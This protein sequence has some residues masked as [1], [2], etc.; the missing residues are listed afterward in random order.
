MVQYLK[1]VLFTEYLQIKDTIETILFT[2]PM[3]TFVVIHVNVCQR[4][5][6][7]ISRVRSSI[8]QSARLAHYQLYHENSI[9]E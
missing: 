1:L 2:R 8:T 4:I 7:I 3:H 5:H 6:I 9:I